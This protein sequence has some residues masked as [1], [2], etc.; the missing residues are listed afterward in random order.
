MN[1]PLAHSS[2]FPHPALGASSGGLDRG[3]AVA[4]SDGGVA[5]PPPAV[6]SF[7]RDAVSAG[8]SVPLG[9]KLTTVGGAVLAGDGVSTDVGGVGAGTAVGSDG[10]DGGVAGPPPAVVTFARDAVSGGASV[11]LGDRLTTA[12]D[13]VLAADGVS[14]DVGGV[15]AGTTVGSDGGDGGVAGPPPAVVSLG[16]DAVSGSASVPLGDR[17]TTAG[18][19][20]LAGD[21]VSADVGGAGTVA[22]GGSRNV[23]REG[24]GRRAATTS[25]L[26]ARLSEVAGC[27]AADAA[28]SARRGATGGRPASGAG[29]ITG[30]LATTAPSD[31]FESP[32]APA[33]GPPWG[34]EATRPR[35]SRNTVS[36]VT[37]A[38]TMRPSTTTME[39]R[40]IHRHRRVARRLA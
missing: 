14:T 25:E 15:G 18:D 13:A 9:G 28:P 37:R 22:A 16:R 26:D 35:G 32:T 19:T 4:A 40:R 11:P 20:V 39:R 31:G 29:A 24:E 10:G 34:S 30:G 21:G 3:G 5:A 1:H 12:G 36:H 7:G 33:D 2:A 17:L 6:V 23:A 8:A 27:G 38:P